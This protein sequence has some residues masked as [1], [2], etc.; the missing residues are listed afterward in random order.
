M[1]TEKPLQLKCV[2]TYIVLRHCLLLF[3]IQYSLN[4]H[5]LLSFTRTLSI[6]SYS[7]YIATQSCWWT[8]STSFVCS[9][10]QLDQIPSSSVMHPSVIT[11]S[12]YV[13][14]TFISVIQLYL[15][16][17]FVFRSLHSYFISQSDIEH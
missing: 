13:V 3:I 2:V 12:R 10:S 14:H 6:E 16:P 17:L 5:L 7:L 11:R 9:G 15:L 8:A 1:F 4:I